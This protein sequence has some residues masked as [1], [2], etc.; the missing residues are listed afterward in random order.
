MGDQLIMIDGYALASIDTSNHAFAFYRSNASETYPEKLKTLM[1]WLGENFREGR[2][3]LSWSSSVGIAHAPE[4]GVDASEILSSAGF[5]ALDKHQP[6]TVYD[7]AIADW[8]YQQQMLMLDIEEALGNG[9]IWLEYQPTVRIQDASIASVEALIRWQHPEF[10]A[11]APDRWVP[12]AEQVG[13]IHQV[14]LWVIDRACSDLGALKSLHGENLA[15]AVNISANDL[16]YPDFLEKVQSIVDHHGAKPSNLILEITETAM[17]A[18]IALAQEVIRALSHNGFKIA[19]DDF[20]T[21]HSSLG[22]LATFELD[23]LKIDR[24]FLSDILT[25]PARQRIF[26]AALDLGEALGLDV[27]VEGVEE[28]AIAAWLQQFPGLYGQGYY[29]GKPEQLKTLAPA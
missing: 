17:M 19:V 25:Q 26:R 20:G 13:M 27:V 21:G 3:S 24:S 7:P 2:F 14:T 6:L 12:L 10:G 9:S 23:E 11:V 5:A 16:T 8:Q 18:D 4:H 29:W 28:E 1:N 15:V 22:T